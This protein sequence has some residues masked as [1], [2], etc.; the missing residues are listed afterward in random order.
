VDWRFD[1]SENK[2]CIPSAYLSSRIVQGNGVKG[3]SN[4]EQNDSIEKVG[5]NT[6]ITIEH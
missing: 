3:F 4:R 2:T 6:S 5:R 1:K